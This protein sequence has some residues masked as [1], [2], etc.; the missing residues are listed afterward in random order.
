MGCAASSRNSFVPVPED[1][2][3]ELQRVDPETAT[4]QVRRALAKRLLKVVHPKLVRMKTVEDLGRLEKLFVLQGQE[5]KEKNLYHNPQFAATMQD[6]GKLVFVSHVWQAPGA[7]SGHGDWKWTSLELASTFDAVKVNVIHWWAKKTDLQGQN[8]QLWLDKVSSPQSEAMVEVVKKWGFFF[9]ENISLADEMLILLS[10]NY[11][12]R[13]WCLYE[14]ACFLALNEFSALHVPME[15]FLVAGVPVEEIISAI[16]GMSVETASCTVEADRAV[17]TKLVEANFT[18]TETFDRYARAC[19]I[20]AVASNSL[21]L[22]AESLFLPDDVRVRE[23]RDMCLLGLK[24]AEDAAALA[25]RL[26]LS[27]LA[28]AVRRLIEL[29]AA[30]APVYE[31]EGSAL[32]DARAKAVI[33]LQKAINKAAADTVV[34][35][36]LA[37]QNA[38]LRGEESPLGQLRKARAEVASGFTE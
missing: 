14:V 20:A 15:L 28:A 5:L 24:G 13:L 7:G 11:P 27:E 21:F 18:S 33:P 19:L 17:L 36:V 12:H 1:L 6:D 22:H 25:E 8:L 10:P 35:V 34:P 38:A 9:L 26:D 3:S 4:P 16:E 32:R 29:A 30:C 2:L 31:G 37:Q 23:G